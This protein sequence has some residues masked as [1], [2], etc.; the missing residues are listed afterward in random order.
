MLDQLTLFDVPVK[1]RRAPRVLMRVVDGGY[2]D[3]T[4]ECVQWWCVRCWYKP[5]EWVPETKV[6]PP[7]PRCNVEALK[8]E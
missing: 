4:G 1:P 8:D 6:R 7:C 5:D 2:I 3:G